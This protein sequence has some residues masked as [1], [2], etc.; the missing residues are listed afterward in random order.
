MNNYNSCSTNT[1]NKRLGLL[2]QLTAYAIK[3]RLFSLDDCIDPSNKNFGIQDERRAESK[4]KPALS[5][6]EENTLLDTIAQREDGFWYDVIV[7]A[8][9]TRL[10]HEGEINAITPNEIDCG[11]KTMTLKRPKTGKWSTIPLTNRA[12]EVVK[13][14]VKLL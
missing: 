10:R 5:I 14:D 11:K 9:D 7:F 6:A 12:L 3:Q 2:R 4:P 13:E 1:V 8:I